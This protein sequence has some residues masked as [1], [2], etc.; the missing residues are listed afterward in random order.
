[1]LLA[2]PFKMETINGP[3]QT[4]P[5]FPPAAHAAIQAVIDVA[6]ITAIPQWMPSMYENMAERLIG[7]D[8]DGGLCGRRAASV[9]SIAPQALI[10][11]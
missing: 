1:M 9:L 6:D 10:V 7:S 11:C 4:R 5:A 3:D 8:G 2:K